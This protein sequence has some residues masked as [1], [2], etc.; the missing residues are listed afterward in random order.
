MVGASDGKRLAHRSSYAEYVGD[1]GKQLVLHKCDTPACVNPDHLRLGSHSENALDAT[2]KL[3]TKFSRASTEQRQAW[4]RQ[5]SL[6]GLKASVGLSLSER[7]DRMS[8]PEPTTG[9]LLWLGPLNGAGYGKIKI[10]GRMS[11]AH[12]VSYAANVCAI[13][14]G[15]MVL[16]KCDTPACVNPNHLFLGNAKDNIADAMKKGRAIMASVSTEQRAEWTKKRLTQEAGLRSDGN[17]ARK[18]WETR[19]ENGREFTMTPEQSSERS[20][21]AWIT[22]I[23][24]YGRLG[25]SHEWSRSGAA[26]KGWSNLTPEAHAKRT[27]SLVEARRRAREARLAA[28]RPN[29]R[30][31]LLAPR[32][33]KPLDQQLDAELVPFVRHWSTRGHSIQSIALAFNVSTNEIE[34]AV[35]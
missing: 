23:E 22:R 8:I 13:P 26:Q 14:V 12:R 3:R 17:I 29:L 34:R 27:Q 9:C 35:A 2:R 19:R 24:K 11:G 30:F 28:K 10:D 5:S 7:V 31:N 6:S 32:T 20:K 15:M 18:G 25:V 21:K 1:P 4:S 16:H 33:T